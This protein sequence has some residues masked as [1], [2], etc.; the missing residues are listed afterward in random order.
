MLDHLVPLNL[1]RAPLKL[2]K[3]GNQ[4]VVWDNLRQKYLVLTPE[5]WVRQHLIHFLRQEKA[6]PA[7]AF[8]LEGGFRQMEKLRRTDILVY[9][10]S[11]PALLVECK[12]PQV[13]LGQDTFDQAARYNRHYH[14]PYLLVSNG[15]NHYCAQLNAQQEGYHFLR[16]VPDYRQL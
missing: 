7:G 11:R 8:D 5:E 14:A 16:E 12:A 9:K 3:K 13:T 4:P 1:P 2:A 10:N 15:L 6:V